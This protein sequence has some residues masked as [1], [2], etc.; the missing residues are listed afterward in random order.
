MRS[1]YSTASK[2]NFSLP[3]QLPGKKLV[4][5]IK[6]ILSTLILIPPLLTTHP[7]LPSSLE[8]CRGAR[9]VPWAT[10]PSSGGARPTVPAAGGTLDNDSEWVARLPAAELGRGSRPTA[11]LGR[12][13]LWGDEVDPALLLSSLPP[14]DG[15]FFFHILYYLN[16]YEFN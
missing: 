1:T 12:R 2:N 4:R 8:R 10:D 5:A 7:F 6:K 13:P 9:A 14:G 15:F 16:V 11:K 3:I